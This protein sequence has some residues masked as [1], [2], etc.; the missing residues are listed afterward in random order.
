[1]ICVHGVQHGYV[2]WLIFIL[3]EIFGNFVTVCF[4]GIC[5][6]PCVMD[7]GGEKYMLPLPNM[8]KVIVHLLQIHCVF[9][10]MS[11]LQSVQTSDF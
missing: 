11:R 8:E 9:I 5:G 4:K 2:Y 6:S 1:M 10:P 7:I 3:V